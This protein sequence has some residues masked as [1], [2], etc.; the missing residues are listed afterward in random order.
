MATRTP[1][2]IRVGVV[3]VGRGQTFM[4]QAPLAGMQ[5]VAICDTWK[6]RLEA[7]GRELDVATYED[8]TAFLEHDMDAVVTA[9]YFHQHAPFAI[10]ALRAGKHVMSETAACKTLAEGVALIREVE[11][12][13]RIYLFAENYPFTAANLEMRRLYQAG[14]IGQALYGD[15]EYNHPMAL[16]DVLR[17]SPGLRHWRNNLPST[18]YCTHALAP[19]MAAT[20]LWPVSV[21]ALSIAAPE[22]HRPL[23]PRRSDL[24][25][26]ILTR[27][28]NGAIFRLFQTGVPGHSI[29]Y[30]IHGERGL[31][32]HTRGPGY[33]G[34]GQLRVVHDPW[35]AREGEIGERT[36]LPEFPAAARKAAEAGHGGGD[37]FTT[38]DFAD[39]IRA[40]RQPY[41]DVHRG[42]AMSIVGI[43][44][45]RSALENGKPVEVP[46]L[47]DEGQRREHEAD[48]WSPY[49]E[50]AGP[51][52]P[53]P[54]IRGDITPSKEAVRHARKVWR[55][56]GYHGN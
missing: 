51:G 5:L 42:V 8:Y 47:R 33:W 32:E 37:Y 38:R 52:Q 24:G 19:L 35:D 1:K 49:P 15:G 20:D 23:S 48:D 14:E 30:R 54:S 4:R 9:N 13:G 36:Y 3:G 41:L 18:Y 39:A 34:P 45:W 10:Q 31:I 22:G 16:D 29:W 50:D 27:M 6:E 12:S 56:I 7:V 53:Y 17:I 28:N 40:K 46:D 55:G 25:S 21:N 2:P 11:R 43:Q 44:A 26:V